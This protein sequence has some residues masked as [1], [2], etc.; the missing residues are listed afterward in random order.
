MVSRDVRAVHLRVMH[1]IPGARTPPLGGSGHSSKKL[2]D[3]NSSNLDSTSRPALR[4]SR[5]LCVK[6]PTSLHD[7]KPSTPCGPRKL[8]R[9]HGR[10]LGKR[11]IYQCVRRMPG[12]IPKLP[13]AL[14]REWH[15]GEAV[16]CRPVAALARKQE[17]CLGTLCR[18]P[19]Q[20]PFEAQWAKLLHRLLWIH[21]RQNGAGSCLTDA[22]PCKRTNTI[23]AHCMAVILGDHRVKPYYTCRFLGSLAD[24]P[25]Q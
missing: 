13:A 17:R 21:L 15:V 12:G 10:V 20:C 25:C 9:R 8:Q 22:S 14:C 3:G 16:T 24:E 23:V 19:A 7:A 5:G 11:P 1:D 6:K 18:K 2:C 4:L